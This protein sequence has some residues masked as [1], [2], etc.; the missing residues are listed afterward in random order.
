MHAHQQASHSQRAMPGRVRVQTRAAQG[1]EE[2]EGAMNA[3]KTG[4][5]IPARVAERAFNNWTL[6][7]SGCYISTYATGS[8]PYAKIGWKTD[9]KSSS[10]LAHRAAWT[11]VHGHIGVLTV[12]HLPTCD[13]RCVNID[14][15]RLLPN[16]ENARRFNGRDW[17]LGECAEGHSN[18]HRYRKS[19]GQ[20]QCRI[21][22]SEWNKTAKS[23]A[24]KD[25]AYRK[26][27]V[28]KRRERRA[29]NRNKQN[30]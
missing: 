30:A 4:I 28:D 8:G 20:W 15:L 17:P 16:F 3:A 25:P 21:C 22:A 14:H 29:R 23:K 7:P 5:E 6:A 19:N 26:R 2:K 1:G 10:A 9:Q 27:E 12:D 11:H 13:R 24:R 18:E